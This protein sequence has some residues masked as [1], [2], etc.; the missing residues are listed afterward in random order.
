MFDPTILQIIVPILVVAIF[1]LIAAALDIWRLKINN[2]ITLPLLFSG[3]VYHL[4]VG[5]YL[6]SPYLLPGILGSIIGL[7]FGIGILLV[8]W[9]M[10]GVGGGDLRLMGAVGAWLGLELALWVFVV[11]AL[12][13][14][15]YAIIM[16]FLSLSFHETW[17]KLQI[18]WYRIV[19]FFELLRAEDS[20]ENSE[21]RRRSQFIPFGAMLFLGVGFVIW[22][23][24]SGFFPLP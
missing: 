24:W 22:G 13:A 2:L 16:I 4:G 20:V 21:G 5:F 8:P 18:I 23:V 7:L 10:G 17:V 3:V 9:L 12:A 14:G 19:A 11:G 15:V 1:A 6:G